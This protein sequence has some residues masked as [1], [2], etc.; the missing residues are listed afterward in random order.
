MS[1]YLSSVVIG[2]EV[3]I[4]EMRMGTFRGEESSSA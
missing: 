3:M 4:H 2:L 1:E